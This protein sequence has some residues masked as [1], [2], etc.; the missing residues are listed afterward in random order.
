VIASSV[1]DWDHFESQHWRA[2]DDWLRANPDHPDAAAIRDEDR[3]LRDYYLH[4]RRG[5]MEWAILVGRRSAGR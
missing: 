3:R 5:R 1:E 2:T 4:H